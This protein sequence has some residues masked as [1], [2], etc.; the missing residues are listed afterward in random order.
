MALE[1]Y[2]NSGQQFN[3]QDFLI[4]FSLIIWYWLFNDIRI[5]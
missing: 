3:R 4:K 2:N 5:F 1:N